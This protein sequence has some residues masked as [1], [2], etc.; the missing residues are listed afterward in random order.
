MINCD[1]IE[2]MSKEVGCYACSQGMFEDGSGE[3]EHPDGVEI[4]ADS[5]NEMMS[6]MMSHENATIAKSPSETKYIFIRLY[7]PKYVKF[8]PSTILKNGISFTNTN[9]LMCTHAAINFS[10]QDNFHGL[11]FNDKDDPNYL[12]LE[13]CTNLKSNKNMLRC[14]PDKSLFYVYALP[15]TKIE[16]SSAK[17][18]V[19]EVLV[20]ND[21]IYTLSSLLRFVLPSIKRKLTDKR[22]DNST[23]KHDA[24]SYNST[25]ELS[26]KTNKFCC[27]TFVAAVLYKNVAKFKKF[28][29]SNKLKTEDFTPSNLS[30]IPSIVKLFEGK[31]K[32]YNK[33]KDK[34]IK[35]N[36]EFNQYK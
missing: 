4:V 10:L 32:D 36:P 17:K 7:D 25:E 12:K 5:D 21:A 34:F 22:L 26:T 33:L 16:Y 31:Y 1:K 14:D 30:I 24:I 20:N 8:N 18:T 11:A 23:N 28:C 27:S 29:D 19:D 35:L 2:E 3:P 15:V 13:E 9:L 6:D